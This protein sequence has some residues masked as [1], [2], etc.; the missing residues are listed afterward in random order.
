MNASHQILNSFLIIVRDKLNEALRNEKQ[1]VAEHVEQAAGRIPT[2]WREA[3][4]S[5]GDG[6]SLG[7]FC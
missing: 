4:V 2:R 5:N 7:D 3:A 6:C 1:N